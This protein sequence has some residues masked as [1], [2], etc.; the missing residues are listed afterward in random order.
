MATSVV[1]AVI[2]WMVTTYRA[3]AALVALVP[4][5]VVFDGPESLDSSGAR[6]LYVGVDDPDPDA[7]ASTAAVA[8]QQYAGLG[9]QRKDELISVNHC[10]RVPSGD[11]TFSTPRAR[12]FE[13]L[14]VVEG[15]VRADLSLGGHVVAALPTGVSDERLRQFNGP[16][17]LVVDLVFAVNGKARI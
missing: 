12:A 10:I 11:G 5:V 7:G 1:P 15:I 2:D 9:G 3:S 17:G 14:A 4:T 13:V 8:T 6:E 16:L